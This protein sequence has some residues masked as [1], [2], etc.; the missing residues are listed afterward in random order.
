MA[1]NGYDSFV[2]FL[3]AHD[4]LQWTNDNAVAG[5]Y[6]ETGRFFNIPYS[7]RRKIFVQLTHNSN[8]GMGGT[9]IFHVNGGRCTLLSFVKVW[10]KQ[11]PDI[12]LLFTLTIVCRYFSLLEHSVR[13]SGEHI[14]LS[15][16]VQNCR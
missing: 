11:T 3:Y 9:W 8:V 6:A 14:H 1:T 15:F 2:I 5:Y 12:D 16:V 10:L 4:E 13:K 7:R